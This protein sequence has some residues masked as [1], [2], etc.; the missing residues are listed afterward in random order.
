MA[1][2]GRVC[3]L[4][5]S[6][7]PALRRT[8]TEQ[9]T[10]VFLKMSLSPLRINICRSDIDIEILLYGLYYLSC[11]FL[12]LPGGSDDVVA[13]GVRFAHFFQVHYLKSQ[14]VRSVSQGAQLDFVCGHAP[15][16]IDSE[17]RAGSL[18]QH[19]YYLQLTVRDSFSPF[20]NIAKHSILLYFSQNNNVVVLDNR[21]ILNPI[22]NEWTQTPSHA[23][24]CGLTASREN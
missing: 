4:S 14:S 7:R 11:P 2:Q 16:N 23:I 9:C 3:V 8:G 24:A 20:V 5:L 22:R 15:S 19:H 1:R 17:V 21:Y 12:L 6:K 10:I 13:V 18:Q